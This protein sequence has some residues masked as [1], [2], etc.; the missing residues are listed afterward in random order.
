MP[1]FLGGRLRDQFIGDSAD[2]F[3][4]SRAIG[5]E[6]PVNGS[7]ADRSQNLAARRNHNDRRQ[8]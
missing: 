8:N 4:R 6:R 2:D 7:E 1:L 5:K 3:V